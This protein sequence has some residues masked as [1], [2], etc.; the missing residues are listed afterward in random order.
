MPYTIAVSKKKHADT[1]CCQRLSLLILNR[2]LT[3][4]GSIN[5]TDIVNLPSVRF[6][7]LLVSS[8]QL[9]QHKCCE[10]LKNPRSSVTPITPI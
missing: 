7:I 1:F 6:P 5:S 10:G 8:Q 4:K 3:E 2:L 9:T